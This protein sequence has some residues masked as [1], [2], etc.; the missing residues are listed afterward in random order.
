M[1][2]SKP[3]EEAS[4]PAGSAVGL[5]WNEPFPILKSIN[6][7]N[8]HIETC[9]AVVQDTH[10]QTCFATRKN[11]LNESIDKFDKISLVFHRGRFPKQWLGW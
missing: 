5:V 2:V 11:H 9:V 1:E 4:Y 7:L 3:M 10:L 8:Y 6:L